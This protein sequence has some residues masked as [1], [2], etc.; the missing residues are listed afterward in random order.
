M[1]SSLPWGGKKLDMTEPLNSKY[2][3]WLVQSV[4]IRVLPRGGGKCSLTL[5]RSLLKFIFRHIHESGN[6]GSKVNKML[7]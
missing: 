4:M 5:K 3:S 7:T 6:S 2:E 1:G